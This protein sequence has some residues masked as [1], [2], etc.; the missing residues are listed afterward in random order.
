MGLSY[1]TPIHAINFPEVQVEAVIPLISA[2]N[3]TLW[4]F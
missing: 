4:Q 2:T 3:R 1:V